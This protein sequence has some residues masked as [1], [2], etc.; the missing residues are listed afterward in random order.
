MTT[1]T[2][3]QMTIWVM[4]VKKLSFYNNILLFNLISDSLKGDTLILVEES[5]I[6]LLQKHKEQSS[7]VKFDSFSV[8]LVKLIEFIAFARSIFNGKLIVSHSSFSQ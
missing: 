6:K 2:D 7:Y 8:K 3:L 5:K 1:S 4:V